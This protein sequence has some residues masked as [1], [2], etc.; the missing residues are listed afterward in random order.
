MHSVAKGQ[1]GGQDARP[2]AA[3]LFSEDFINQVKV[4]FW[5][6]YSVGKLQSVEVGTQQQQQRNS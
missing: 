1:A 4:T 6:K 3:V 2:F 5:S